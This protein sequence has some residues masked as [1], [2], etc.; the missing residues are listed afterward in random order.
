MLLQASL[1]LI[2]D[3]R[4]I[5]VPAAPD[6]HLLVCCF[7][8]S[9]GAVLIQRK[10]VGYAPYSDDTIAAERRLF[11]YFVVDT[12]TGTKF[13]RPNEG[14]SE[15]KGFENTEVGRKPQL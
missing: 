8:S 11:W 1:L 3:S 5:T 7:V 15:I 4:S 14:E 10:W 13:R 12:T 6:L 9:D 2:N